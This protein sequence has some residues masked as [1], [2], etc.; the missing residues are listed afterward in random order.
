[1][2]DLENHFGDDASLD[3]KDRVEIESY[4]LANSA[5][6]STKEAAFYIAKSIKKADTIAITKTPYWKKRHAKIDKK[7]FNSPKVKSKANC[8]ACHR[9]FEKGIID[10]SL[11]AIPKG[12]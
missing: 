2:A 11:I 10:D 7:I 1:M 5:E 12:V 6:N 3:K 9:G 4:L 8:K